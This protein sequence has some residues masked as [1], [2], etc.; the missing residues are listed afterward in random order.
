MW[1]SILITSLGD[2]NICLIIVLV[3]NDRGKY[4]GTLKKVALI[5]AGVGSWFDKT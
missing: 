1:Q 2:T 5:T 3:Q 4:Y